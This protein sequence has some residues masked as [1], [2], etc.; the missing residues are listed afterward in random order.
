MAGWVEV[1]EPFAKPP[2]LERGTTPTG[3]AD[4]DDFGEDPI[5][6]TAVTLSSLDLSQR[7]FERLLRSTVGG[8]KMLGFDA[9]R[10]ALVDVT[11]ESCIIRQA[12]FRMSRLERVAFVDCTFDDVDFFEATLTDVEFTESTL[13]K[14]N[15]DRVAGERVDLR[16]TKALDL[17]AM[18]SMS[19]YLI[20]ETQLAQLAP[21][22]AMNAGFEIATQFPNDER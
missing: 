15:L 13:V 16:A 1:D 6:L 22:L 5:E 4:L 17:L 21:Q 8:C 20:D 9:S 3:S 19:G 2:R 7:R 18:G 14:V 11:F 12:S 10:G